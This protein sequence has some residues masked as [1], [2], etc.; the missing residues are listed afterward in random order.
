MKKTKD[1]F[2][3]HS[4]IYQKYRPHYPPDL[5]KFI[6]SHTKSRENCWDCATG[7]GQVARVLASHFKD[8]RATDISANQLGQAPSLPNVTYGRQRAENTDFEDNL[9]DLVTVAQAL[10]WF[11]IPAFLKEVKRV[12]RPGGVLAVWGYGL[13]RLG[14]PMDDMISH[15]YSKVVGPYWDGERLHIDSAYTSIA[16]PLS[17]QADLGGFSIVRSMDKNTLKGY[18]TSWSS[19]QNYMK[20]HGNNPVD[21]LM[22]QLQPH[23]QEGH[24]MEA[25]FPI[26]G[27]VGT[28]V[29]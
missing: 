10:H 7:N 17:G 1:R 26:F 5:Y 21:G 9:F 23:W 20:R 8:V 6:L 4:E 24:P 14:A 11:D 27:A 16:L 22:A 29:K 12:S 2:S 15:F 18:L 3:G 25:V 28:I 19:V 13:L